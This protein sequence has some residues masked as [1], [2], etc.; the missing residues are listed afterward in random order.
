MKKELVQKLQQEFPSYFRNLY[1]DPKDS[2]LA[3]GLECNDGWFDIIW[4]VCLDIRATGK[5]K[6][7][8]FTQIKEKF[9]GLRLYC[10]YAHSDVWDIIDAAEEESYKVCENCGSRDQVTSEGSWI[11]TLCGECRK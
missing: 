8:F 2:C 4:K 10:N 6:E 9:G 11:T 7:F 1:G 3:F 5:D